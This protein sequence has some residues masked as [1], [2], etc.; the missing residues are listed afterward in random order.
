MHKN[1]NAGYGSVRQQYG[2]PVYGKFRGGAGPYR[3]PKNNVPVNIIDKGNV[4]EV[5]VY[6][7]GFDKE[8]ITVSVSD[9]LLSINGTR[10]LAEGEAPNFLRQEY[11][12]KSFERVIQLNDKVDIAAISAKQES[13]ILIVTLPKKPEASKPEQTIAIA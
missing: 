11:P 12:I 7:L 13:G 1:C 2:A 9:D 10:D 8:N 5:Y 4:F 6:A 3:R